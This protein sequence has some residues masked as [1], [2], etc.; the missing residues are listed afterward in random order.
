MGKGQS[1]E[2]FWTAGGHLARPGDN[3]RALAAA[4]EVFALADVE[5]NDAHDAWRQQIADGIAFVDDFT[6]WAR[7]WKAAEHAADVAATRTWDEPD[8]GRVVLRMKGRVDLKEAPYYPAYLLQSRLGGGVSM[9]P[10]TNAAALQLLEEVLSVM[11]G[12]EPVLLDK[13][14][15]L[16]SLVPAIRRTVTTMKAHVAG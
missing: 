14:V 5:P 2:I 10:A 7:I 15:W 13:L 3:E 11:D 9:I 1:L 12:D 16:Q 8:A 6:G 4:Y